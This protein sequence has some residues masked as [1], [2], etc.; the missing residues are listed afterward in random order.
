[1]SSASVDTSHLSVGNDKDKIHNRG[2]IKCGA[3]QSQIASQRCCREHTTTCTQT[4][5]Y[6]SSPKAIGILGSKKWA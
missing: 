6:T 1:M 5:T 2:A 3:V 4:Q